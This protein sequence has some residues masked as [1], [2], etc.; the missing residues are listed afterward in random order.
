MVMHMH[1]FQPVNRDSLRSGGAAGVALRC[2]RHDG[3]ADRRPLGIV[4]ARALPAPA[5]P[6]L[7]QNRTQHL[8]HPQGRWEELPPP[9]QLGRVLY[10]HL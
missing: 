3:H 2:C 1:G 7:E 6:V 10:A 5:L 8:C 9:P 4:N